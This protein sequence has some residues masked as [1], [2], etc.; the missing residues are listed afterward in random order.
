MDSVTGMRLVLEGKNTLTI[1]EQNLEVYEPASKQRTS[2]APIASDGTSGK[3]MIALYD[4]LWASIDNNTLS[5]DYARHVS[6][7][8]VTLQKKT[9]K[10]KGTNGFADDAFI[11]PSPETFVASLLARA[12]HNTKPQKRA[13]AL[14]NPHAGPGHAVRQWTNEVKP[15]FD[16]ARM[17][18]DMVVLKRGGEATALVE[19]ADIEKYDT[20]IACSG[21][22]TVHEIFNGL[23]KRPDART[24][25][26]KVAVSHV[27]CG[28]G[29]AMACN[30]YGSRYPSVAA[31]GIIKG[32]VTP[33]DL[34]SVTQGSQRF[35][36][37]LSQSVGI[38]AESDLGT[39]NMRWMGATRFDVGMVTR[40]FQQ[41]CYPCDLAVKVEIEGKDKIKAHYRRFVQGDVGKTVSDDL[42][43]SEIEEQG[44]PPLKYGTA[45][46]KLPEGWELVSYDNI[47]NF[48][49]G[50]MA[51]M[52][53]NANFFPAS[54]IS[55][56]YMDLVT[57]NGDLPILTA[58]STLL[59]V[60]AGTFFEK[61]DVNYR[62]ISA[63]RLIPRNQEDGYISIDG[64]K[65]PFQAFQAEIHPSLGRVLS[66]NG[67]YEA[68]GPT[69]W[70]NAS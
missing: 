6:K 11:E 39:E 49:C 37:F 23:G 57:I 7:S 36:S 14:L 16:A 69:G 46:D 47:G 41:K 50:N 60:E 29:N 31:L 18:V 52:A 58:V 51:W 66:K 68:A 26:A 45:Q 10:I 42:L 59:A 35:L 53:P 63:Y 64:E 19:K 54:L 33:M 15:L 9:Y 22:G 55:D 70:E 8:S 38:V 12:Y 28:S 40:V 20:I 65:V 4:I 44:L 5:I 56:G 21:D 32:V 3:Q 67:V 61:P 34:A 30:L 25:L 2:C 48:Y 1:G 27:P 24:A 43:D 62:K 17:E 13:Y